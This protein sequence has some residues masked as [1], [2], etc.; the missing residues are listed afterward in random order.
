MKKIIGLTFPN[1]DNWG[2]MNDPA[3][4]TVLPQG[5][6]VEYSDENKIFNDEEVEYYLCGIYI[7][8]VKEF[9]EW[10]S[11]HDKNKIIV[12][13]YQPTL[14]P[15]EFVDH[16]WKVVVGLCDNLL[17][18]IMQEGQIVNGITDYTNL[19]RYDLWDIK[20]NMIFFPD[21]MPNDKLI[22]INTSSGCTMKC[23]FCCTPFMTNSVKSKPLEYIQKEIDYMMS[24]YGHCDMCFVK[25]ENV[26]LQKDW[27]E[28]L[29]IISKLAD[30]LVIFVSA[31]LLNE[32]K[33]KKLV[34]CNVRLV[35]IGLDDIND[36]NGKNKNLVQ[37]CNL[38]HDNGIYVMLSHIID[39]TTII[40]EEDEEKYY[41]ALKEKLIA[42]KSAA[43]YS[44]FLLPFPGTPIYNKYKHLL[45]GEEDYPLYASYTPALLIKDPILIQRML[46]NLHKLC[47]EYFESD[48]Y[49]KNVRKY[50][51]G[52]VLTFFKK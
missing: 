8:G 12:G 34:D 39:P 23:E 21:L 35:F 1:K 27:E 37:V 24:L 22:T 29:K 17:K 33:I 19:P 28:R 5:S 13:G 7:T 10:A 15:H 18:T 2:C 41:K 26:L 20:K 31:N 50:K 16:A 30:R 48:W 9:K 4:L 36:L 32:E 42:C 47:D 40:K 25:D 3:V 44:N 49:N 6:N 52:D 51:C 45:R 43:I 11:K 14:C 38:L 46:G